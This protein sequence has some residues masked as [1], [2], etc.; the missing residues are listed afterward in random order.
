M[1]NNYS[2]RDVDFDSSSESKKTQRQLS[3]KVF[4]QPC[5]ANGCPCTVFCG[6][7]TQGITVCEFHEGVHGKYFPQVTSGLIQYQDLINLAERLLRDWRLIDDYN[8]TSNHPYVVQNLT[9]YFQAIG[10][11]E[12]T[13]LTNIPCIPIEGKQ[14]FRDESAYDLGNRIKRWVRIQVVKP[15][16]IENSEES[17][18]EKT[19]EQLSPLSAYVNQLERNAIRKQQDDE[20]YF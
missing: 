1:S 9:E 15:Y 10:I 5:R 14:Q 2:M 3:S 8:S 6:Q 19:V 4:E 7:L 12:L 11:P 18:K 13:P 16:M 20:A 17:L